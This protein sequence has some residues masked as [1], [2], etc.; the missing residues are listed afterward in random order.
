M[1]LMIYYLRLFNEYIFMGSF[2]YYVSY[3]ILFGQF[4]ECIFMGSFD[5][6][7]SHDILFEV[8]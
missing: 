3:D 7:V 4:N 6:Y 1:S 5:Y 2:D 8:I